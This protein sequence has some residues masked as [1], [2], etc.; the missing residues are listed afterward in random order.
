MITTFH[1]G[2]SKGVN[3]QLANCQKGGTPAPAKGGGV[4]PCG[5]GSDELN[6][7]EHDL[8]I[9]VPMRAVRGRARRERSGGATPALWKPRRGVHVQPVPGSGACA[10]LRCEA[11]IHIHGTR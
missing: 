4:R 8:R 3:R 7:S 1:M 2:Q 11:N 10:T 9:S 6:N 5:T